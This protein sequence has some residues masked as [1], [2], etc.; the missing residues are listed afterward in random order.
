MQRF[1]Y[2]I[3]LN[4]PKHLE[5]VHYHV[6]YSSM[7]HWMFDSCEKDLLQFEGEGELFVR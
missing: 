4:K 7:F 5:K 1:L 6:L 3:D 2:F